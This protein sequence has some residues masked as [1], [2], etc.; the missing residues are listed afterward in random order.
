MSRLVSHSIC[1]QNATADDRFIDGLEIDE[2]DGLLGFDP[3]GLR[4]DVA[5]RWASVCHL[6]E[7]AVASSGVINEVLLETDAHQLL[8]NSA[9]IEEIKIVAEQYR[10]SRNGFSDTPTS[11]LPNDPARIRAWLAQTPEICIP[12]ARF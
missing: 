4:G 2:A 8:L 3:T 12:T 7:S 11:D 10:V 9:A 6:F 5:T 1:F